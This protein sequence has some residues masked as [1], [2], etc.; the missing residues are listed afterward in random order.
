MK[1]WLTEIIALDHSTQE[2]ALWQGDIV[3]APTLRLAQVWCDTNGKG[4]MK[5][6]GELTAIIPCKEGS[7]EPDME[8]KID[9]KQIQ[10]N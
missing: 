4:Y 9:F 2:I 8:K 10:N 6:V 1:K 7:F 5:V 3:E